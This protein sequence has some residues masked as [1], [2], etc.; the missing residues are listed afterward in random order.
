MKI[1]LETERTYLREMTPDDAQN[2]Y[3][4]NS[5][6]LVIQY[7][8]DEAFESV[9]DARIFLT[10]YDHYE[11]YGFGRWAVI[12]KETNEYLGWCGLKYSADEN[13]FDIGFRFHQRFWNK[14]FASETA[15]ACIQLGFDKF[16][17]ETIVGRAMKEN[18][19]SIRVL[20][21]C[22]LTFL[23]DYQFDD[24]EGVIYSIKKTY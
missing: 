8:G 5:D 4:L 1:I 20:E 10:K 14:G 17:M 18:L 12:S 6:P 2:A 22:G 15:R 9:E 7:T 16:N 13:E 21:K 3:E 24:E 23:S 19:A 11:K